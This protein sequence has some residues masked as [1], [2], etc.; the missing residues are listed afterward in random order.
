VDEDDTARARRQLE[1][2]AEQ[3]AAVAQISQ[4]ALTLSDPQEVYDTAVHLC[5]QALEAQITVL[6]DASP[7]SGELRML[8]ALGIPLTPGA[9]VPHESAPLLI[10]TVASAAPVKIDDWERGDSPELHTRLLLG[11]GV[12]ASACV[13]LIRS[14]QAVGGLAAHRLDA[15]PFDEQDMSFLQSM[16]NAV[17]AY[18]DRRALFTRLQLTDRLAA[19]G[20]LASGVAHEMNNPLTYVIANLQFLDEELQGLGAPGHVLREGELRRAVEALRE[21]REGAQRLSVIVRDMRTFSTGDSEVP[22]TFSLVP[23]LLSSVNVAQ[24]ELRM[25]ARLD[26]DVTPVPMVRGNAARLSQVFLNLLV[27]ATQAI[28]PGSPDKNQVAVRTRTSAGEVLIEVS[29]TGVGIP[30]ANLRRIFDP[31]F[32]TK[33]PGVGTGLGLAICHSIVQKMG[34]RI[35]VESEPGRGAT[36]RVFLPPSPGFTQPNLAAAPRARGRVLL[37]D[38]EPLVGMALRR[39]LLAEHDVVLVQSGRAALE[40][41][42]GQPFD[43]L[44]SDIMMP[45]MTGLELY[46]RLAREL[47]ALAQR[48]LFITGGVLHGVDTPTRPGIAVLEKPIEV[49]TF[50]R[51]VRKLVSQ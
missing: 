37:V 23:V 16:A 13:P 35:E 25:R 7:E 40:Q 20:T 12:R 41:V 50:R 17:Q 4:R 6:V 10:K 30:A 26:L 36:F 8:S 22:T 51:A 43:A 45:E 1:T 38:D 3:Q 15:R 44:V 46:D 31:F 39:A 11:A 27:N 42:A 33:A 32:T 2:R 24:S 5:A 48:M 21:A 18:S 14:G 29:D 19:V 49:E 47:P 34:G 9:I 28:Q